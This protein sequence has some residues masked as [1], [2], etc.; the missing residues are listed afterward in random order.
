MATMTVIRLAPESDT[1]AIASS[2][3]GIA[4]RRTRPSPASRCRRGRG[5]SLRAFRPRGRSRSTGPRPRL[6]R[7]ATHACRTR[8]D[9]HTSR[10]NWSVPNQFSSLGGF[11]P[12]HRAESLAG[13]RSTSSGA[14]DRG[15]HEEQN[16]R[17]AHDHERIARDERAQAAEHEWRRWG[18]ALTVSLNSGSSGRAVCTR[19]R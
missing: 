11:Q 14:E 10:P 5:C 3:P 8:R 6:R 7:S 16:D 4:G 2:T 19:C 18:S 12:V 9:V 13:R 1:R 17:G 15:Q